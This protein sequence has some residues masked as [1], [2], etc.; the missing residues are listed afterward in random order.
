MATV[1]V[2]MR[3]VAYW[4]HF[5]PLRRRLWAAGNGAWGMFTGHYVTAHTCCHVQNSSISLHVYPRLQH[6]TVVNAGAGCNFLA[7]AV[8]NSKY[9]PFRRWSFLR[10]KLVPPPRSQLRMKMFWGSLRQDIWTTALFLRVPLRPDIC[11]IT[12]LPGRPFR[13][14]GGAP[15]E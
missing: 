15:L 10:Y 12:F 2:H 9:H 4:S 3:S 6:Y 1:R 13:G 11:P 14:G 8:K 5:A 7:E